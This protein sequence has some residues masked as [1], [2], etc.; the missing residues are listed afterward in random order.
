MKNIVLFGLTIALVLVAV[1]IDSQWI[2]SEEVR[3]ES[4]PHNIRIGTP[5]IQDDVVYFGTMEGF[6]YAYDI[7]TG[8]EMWRYQAGGAVALPPV[9][10]ER[11]IY[12]G[13]ESGF[14]HALDSKTG[15]EIWR[16]QTGQVEY[17]IRDNFVNS[18]PTIKDGTIYF[19]S[20]DFNF[21]AVNAATGKELWRF[22]LGEEIQQIET[23]IFNDIAYIG[24]WN[25][26]LFAIDITTGK[27]VWR[28]Q[29]NNYHEGTISI[30]AGPEQ[31]IPSRAVPTG[32]RLS[33]QV[34]FV[35]VS[36]IITQESVYFLDWTGNLFAIDIK[37]GKQQWR[38]KPETINMRHVGSRFYMT[39]FDD[40]IYFSTLEDRHLYGI[41][42]FT[43]EPIWEIERAGWLEG[44]IP[45][46][47]NIAFLLEFP[48]SNNGVP[49]GFKFQ[50]HAFDLK[51][52]QR[53]YTINDISLF[54][55][56]KEGTVYYGSLD[57]SLKG[58]DIFTGELTWKLEVNTT[59]F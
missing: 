50:A 58:L 51:S 44:P 16:F 40:V 31:F 37:T 35:T 32:E 19:T 43:G 45:G 14:M 3:A 11:R 53:L 8:Q 13:G 5:S 23:P 6:V 28:S 57:G 27:E 42:R 12:F 39:L 4:A 1:F 21:Y 33:N 25:G 30:G 48:L 22:H 29:T 26:F 52:H 54:P 18:I 20:E 47:G 56:T 41:D 9:I 36:P 46:A 2:H 7:P 59:R 17:P 10:D 15:Q 55:Y 49:E 34:P 38:F 24:S